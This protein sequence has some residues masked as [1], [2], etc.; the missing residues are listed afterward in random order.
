MRPYPNIDFV[1]YF[2]LPESLSILIR[3]SAMTSA[4]Y[5]SM[6]IS[7]ETMGEEKAV[8]F[9]LLVPDVNLLLQHVRI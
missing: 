7:G 2:F 4:I 9:F 5:T 6:N 8:V 3:D 1:A